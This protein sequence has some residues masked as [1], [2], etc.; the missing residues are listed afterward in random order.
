MD[1]DTVTDWTTARTRADLS[2]LGPG[3]AALAGGTWLFG[4]PQPGLRRLVDLT[5]MGWPALVEDDTGLEVAATC[6][7]TCLDEHFAASAWPTAGLVAACV[8]AFA[9]SPKVWQ[10][11][12]VGGN[13]CLALPAG[14][15]ISLLTALDATALL[16]AVD[17]RDRRVRVEDLVTGPSRND[18]A[19][20]EVVR[21][22]HVPARTLA[23][24][25]AYRRLALTR[26]GRSGV[27]VVGR[28]D[29]DGAVAL[30][31]TAGT[32]RPVRLG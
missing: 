24:R 23:A 3:A 22:F 14:P 25:T 12:T 15:M 18:L 6:T 28:S 5:G 1:L 16:W 7:V 31:V 2:R 17:G 21:S 11:A 29:P 8:R 32:A 27:V 26:E 30:T 13:V 9:S 4:E 19:A 20:G 10:L